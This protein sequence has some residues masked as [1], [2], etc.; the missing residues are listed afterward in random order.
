MN[1]FKRCVTFTMSHN[2][3]TIG[4][5]VYKHDQ[6]IFAMLVFLP[7]SRVDLVRERIISKGLID[8]RVDNQFQLSTVW[9]ELRRIGKAVKVCF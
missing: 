9:L 7:A 5:N 2:Y 6:R 8:L 1:I 3:V 4:H